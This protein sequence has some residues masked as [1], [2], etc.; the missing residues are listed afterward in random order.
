MREGFGQTDVFGAADGQR[1]AGDARMVERQQAGAGVFGG[2]AGGASTRA[3]VGEGVLDGGAD[4]LSREVE[5]GAAGL[6]DGARS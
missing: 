1:R 3:S 6:K 4:E 2:E 5:A